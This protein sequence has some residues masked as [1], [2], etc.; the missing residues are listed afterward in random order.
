MILAT[1]LICYLV[2]PSINAQPASLLSGFKTYDNPNT[3]IKI[4]YLSTWI[5]MDTPNSGQDYTSLLTIVPPLS[6]D[7]NV[8]TNFEIFVKPVKYHEPSIDFY[9]RDIA[10]DLTSGFLGEH[11]L[12]SSSNSMLSGKKAYNITTSSTTNTFKEMKV[13]RT[14]VIIGDKDYSIYFTA[15]PSTFDNLLPV[16]Q[17]MINSFLLN[18]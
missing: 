3:G 9:T 12:S 15:D 5:Y 1:I 2:F 17:K 10:R 14:G 11:I 13:L 4:Q 7:P 18:K 8:N 6:E 16:V